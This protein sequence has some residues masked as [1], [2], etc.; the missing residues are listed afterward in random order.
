MRH[1]VFTRRQ[2]GHGQAIAASDLANRHHLSGAGD[3]S[4]PGDKAFELA[5]PLLLK[6]TSR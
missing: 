1:E 2:G 3:F 5:Y 4:D 6:I